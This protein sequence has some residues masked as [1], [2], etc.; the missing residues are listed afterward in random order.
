M[1]EYAPYLIGIV[2]IA[3]VAILLMRIGW[4]HRQGRQAD[5]AAPA[6]IPAELGAPMV[7]AVGQYVCT[8]T[9]GDW[10]DR[11]SVH[12]LGMKSNADLSLHP[13]GA[14]FSRTGAPDVFIPASDLESVRRESGMAGKFVESGGLLVLGWRLGE[15]HVDTGF[16]PRAAEDMATLVAA[17]ETLIPDPGAPAPTD[18]RT[19]PKKDK[20]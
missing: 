13:E 11:I 1:S 4:R 6:P 10:L 14:L 12:S 7:E 19:A 2:V 5:V 20:P 17:A 3:A 18:D 9:A 15:H 16:R 8:T